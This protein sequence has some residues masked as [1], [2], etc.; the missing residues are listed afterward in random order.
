MRRSKLNEDGI[1]GFA[2]FIAMFLAYVTITFVYFEAIRVPPEPQNAETTEELEEFV[3]STPREPETPLPQGTVLNFEDTEDGAI[4]L[5]TNTDISKLPKE[6]PRNFQNYLT[7]TLPTRSEVNT[8]GCITAYRIAKIS[9]FNISGSIGSAD[10]ETKKTSDDCTSGLDVVWY[11][12]ETN[13]TWVSENF[14]VLPFCGV[15]EELPIYREFM[16]ECIND[17]DSVI[18][19]NPNGSIKNRS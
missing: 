14:G 7:N 2:V 5:L 17:D 16:P 10:P 18:I 19:P 9:N 1:S 12:D 4:I 15:L 8:Y 11:L 6:T 13:W 3:T